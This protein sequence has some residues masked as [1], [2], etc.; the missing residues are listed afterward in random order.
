MEKLENF[1]GPWMMVSTAGNMFKEQSGRENIGWGCIDTQGQRVSGSLR[2]FA[3][4]LNKAKDVKEDYYA[5]YGL[6]SHGVTHAEMPYDPSSS[7]L[8][9]GYYS[10]AMSLVLE[11]SGNG[12]AEGYRV[13]DSG[14][15]STVG[16]HSTSFSVGGGLSATVGDFNVI[17]MDINTSFGTTFSSPDVQIAASKMKRAVRWDVTL[18]G[19]GF[20]GSSSPIN[21]LASSFAGYQWYFGV[22]FETPG[23]DIPTI[24]V[25]PRISWRFDYTRGL[26]KDEIVWE[27]TRS[28]DLE[29][30]QPLDVT[31]VPE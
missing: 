6:M 26:L 3:Y 2:F 27:E 12:D 18:P 21:P 22:I 25:R 29:F 14:P 23:G 28:F 30:K 17:G 16:Q 10:P 1:G 15:T 24:T 7:A 11:V 31:V 8:S 4:K 9:V 5:V 13:Y 20:L 19:V